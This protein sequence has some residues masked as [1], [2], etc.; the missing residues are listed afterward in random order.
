MGLKSEPVLLWIHS[1]VMVKE[2]VISLPMTL[3]AEHVMARQG[4]N[5]YHNASYRMQKA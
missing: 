1:C 5:E 4:F 2:E 3:H